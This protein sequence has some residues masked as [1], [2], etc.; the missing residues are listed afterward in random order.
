MKTNKP[1]TETR[2]YT[3]WELLNR[4]NKRGERRPVEGALALGL[5]TDLRETRDA[6]AAVRESRERLDA[7]S[8]SGVLYGIRDRL[9]NL[10]YAIDAAP[11]VEEAEV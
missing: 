6:L 9:R 10:C 5:V 2:T 1:R 3:E 11:Y 4:A 8:H 7:I